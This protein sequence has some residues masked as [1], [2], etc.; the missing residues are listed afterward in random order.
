MSR[1]GSPSV[2]SMKAAAVLV[3]VVVFVHCVSETRAFHSSA[4]SHSSATLVAVHCSSSS[5]KHARRHTMTRTAAAPA[6]AAAEAEDEDVA[7]AAPSHQR[8]QK[9]FQALDI[10]SSSSDAAAAGILQDGGQALGLHRW[11]RFRKGGKKQVLRVKKV[12]SADEKKESRPDSDAASS[13]ALASSYRGMGGKGMAMPVELVDEDDVGA[14]STSSTNGRSPSG[15]SSSSDG[16]S[17]VVG[18]ISRMF[19]DSRDVSESQSAK[20]GEAAFE[21]VAKL[22]QDT[23]GLVGTS[24]GKNSA[25]NYQRTVDS[26]L[27]RIEEDM[28]MLDTVVG[29]KAQLT[30]TEFVFLVATTIT[31]GVSPFL[32][33]VK[34][35]YE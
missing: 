9:P 22:A 21:S 34:V 4:G 1:P 29:S 7:I 15:D 24:A 26:A 16:D 10:L 19:G 2:V 14:T 11:P 18:A 13:L 5:C 28:R 17:S 6:S 35:S 32:F 25:A 3:A 30:G 27:R 20:A 31:A 8:R 23:V 12:P 33:P